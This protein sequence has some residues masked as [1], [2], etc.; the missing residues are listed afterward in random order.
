MLHK[1][2]N[3]PRILQSAK[4]EVPS[5]QDVCEQSDLGKFMVRPRGLA[6]SPWPVSDG[7]IV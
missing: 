6:A 1:K 7:Q 3:P 4:N 5:S 2:M